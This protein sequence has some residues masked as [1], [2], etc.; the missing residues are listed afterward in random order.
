MSTVS[1]VENGAV[2]LAG[3]ALVVVGA[4]RG[5]ADTLAIGLALLGVKGGT[6][7]VD[8]RTPSPP[9]PPGP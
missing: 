9:T 2:I 5:Q 4:L 7:V 8:N 1:M 3:L 6:Y